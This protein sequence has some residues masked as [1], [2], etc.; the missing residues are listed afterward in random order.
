MTTTTTVNTGIT[1][2]HQRWA[3]PSLGSMTR[4]DVSVRSWAPGANSWPVSL[5]RRSA[6]AMGPKSR[7]EKAVS[8]AKY[9]ARSG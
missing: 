6:T 5:A 2:F 1:A 8:A 7:P 4:S 3:A 9:S